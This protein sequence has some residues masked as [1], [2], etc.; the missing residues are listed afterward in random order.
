MTDEYHHMNQI[1]PGLWIGDLHSATDVDALRA[2]HIQSILTVM[3]GRF[4][5]PEVD[6]VFLIALIYSSVLSTIDLHPT[7]NSLGRCGGR[8]R[9]PASDPFNIIYTS[10]AR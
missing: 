10:R 5:I 3:R 1:L 6:P 4:S 9:T 2:N 7:S 8:R